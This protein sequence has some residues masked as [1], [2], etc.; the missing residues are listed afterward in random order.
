[1]AKS[2]IKNQ[3]R[4]SGFNNGEMTLQQLADRVDVT[5]QTLI[6]IKAGRYTH[7]LP[8]TSRIVNTFGAPIEQV[9]QYDE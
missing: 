4:K 7:S 6:A 3:V 9:F 1:M 2:E 8:P 5:G